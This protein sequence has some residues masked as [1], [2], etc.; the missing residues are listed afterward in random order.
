[1]HGIERRRLATGTLAEFDHGH[2]DAIAELGC[3]TR[4]APRAW[5]DEREGAGEVSASRLATN[6]RHDAG[7]GCRAVE[8]YSGYDKGPARVTGALGCPKSR[9]R[10]CELVDECLCWNG[11]GAGSGFRERWSPEGRAW[12]VIGPGARTAT[13]VAPPW[14]WPAQLTDAS[15]S[16]GLNI[17]SRPSHSPK[18][19]RRKASSRHGPDASEHKLTICVSWLRINADV[20]DGPAGHG[21]AICSISFTEHLVSLAGAQGGS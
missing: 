14:E 13:L 2:A 8:H 1:M 18:G 7:T 20:A 16:P 19:V 10:L 6:P 4:V 12:T 3:P 15:P 21:R 17:G 11:E 5:R 9:E